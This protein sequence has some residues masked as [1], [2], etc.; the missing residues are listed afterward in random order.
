[1]LQCKAKAWLATPSIASFLAQP[2]A[3]PEASETERAADAALSAQQ[4]AVRKG[5]VN[6]SAAVAGGGKKRK[7][8]T[9]SAAAVAAAGEDGASSS[10]KR[11]SEGATATSA[12]DEARRRKDRE[13]DTVSN[14]LLIDMFVRYHDIALRRSVLRLMAFSVSKEMQTPGLSDTK[15]KSKKKKSGKE[16]GGEEESTAASASAASDETAPDASAAADADESS[17][18]GGALRVSSVDELPEKVKREYRTLGAVR[19]CEVVGIFPKRYARGTCNAHGRAYQ[20][21][22][23]D[24]SPCRLPPLL[25][26]GSVC[27]ACLC[28]LCCCV[29]AQHAASAL[30]RGLL[31]RCCGVQPQTA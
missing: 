1:M 15:A 28:V 24:S 10:K 4:T 12:D 29:A 20:K 8:K 25:L 31:L 17:K 22:R 19:L 26:A 2:N 3:L 27:F 11:K 9:S 23:T 21:L 18:S 16:A 30:T 14:G 6:G 5:S 7:S 13:K